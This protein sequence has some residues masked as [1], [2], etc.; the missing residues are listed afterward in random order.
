MNNFNECGVREMCMECQRHMFWLG[1]CANVRE[2]HLSTGVRVFL[3]FICQI[4]LVVCVPWLSRQMV[5]TFLTYVL[6]YAFFMSN[7]RTHRDDGKVLGFVT[8]CDTYV[9]NL[10]KKEISREN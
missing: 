10:K 1:V 7:L 6:A 8:K 3:L 5:H 4:R 9:E 2:A